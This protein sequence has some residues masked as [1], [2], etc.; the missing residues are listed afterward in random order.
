MASLSGTLNPGVNL[1]RELQRH[2]K[3]GTFPLYNTEGIR[4]CTDVIKKVY[5]HLNDTT[6]NFE[7]D[8]LQ[9]NF[10]KPNLLVNVTLM[11]RQKRCVLAYL[12]ARMEKIQRMR[13]EI[14]SILTPQLKEKLSVDE[15][16]FFAEYDKIL[17]TY[18]RE[19]QFD[20]WSEL[21]VP[22]KDLFIEIRVLV[23]NGLIQTESGTLNLQKGTQHSVR[24]SDVEDL[25]KQG[26]VE[27]ITTSD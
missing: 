25:I 20:S 16:V 8:E 13:W 21:T 15:S 9:N 17:T 23:D 5:Q 19:M 18:A 12:M 1:L 6:T 10:M 4:A 3:L 27:H 22:P 26:I 24:R 7:E 14:G 11:E 2:D